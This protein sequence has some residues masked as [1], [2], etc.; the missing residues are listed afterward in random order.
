MHP[1]D[2]PKVMQAIEEHFTQQTNLY[3]TEHRVL[4]KDG[5]YKWILDRGHAIW[6]AEGNAIRI[7]G[8]HTDIS[9]QKQAQEELKES[10]QRLELALEASGDGWW[11]LDIVKNSGYLSPRWWQML[12]Y[13]GDE[14]PHTFATW[15]SLIHPDDFPW[16][17]QI[18]MDYLADYH[19][20][21]YQFDYRLRTRSGE[22]KW[23]TSYGKVVEW[24]ADGKPL[25]M[26]GTHK[27]ISERKP[28]EEILKEREPFL[29]GIGDNFPNGFLYQIV[30]ET[31]GRDRFYY[32]SAGVERLTGLKPKEVLED[33]SLLHHLI[34][35][36]DCAWMKE[37][38]QESLENLSIFDVQ[39]R[40]RTIWDDQYRWV[41]LCSTPRRLNDGRIVWD[42]IHLDITN[43][44]N[45]EETL[46]QNQARLAESQRIAH[47]GN[48]E[49]DLNNGQITWSE[50]LFSILGRDRSL[51]EPNYEENLQL[52]DL[53][54][55]QKLHEAIE[56]AIHTGE[57]YRLTL[58]LA[59][60]SD[61]GIHYIEL[62]GRVELNATG[63]LTRLYGTG[64][65]ITERVQTEQALQAAKDAA[66]TANRAKSE[67]LANMSHEIRTPMNAILGFAD[68]LSSMIVEPQAKAYLD[69][70]SSS[71]KTLLTLIND[72]LD[73]SKIE[74]GK[75]EFYQDP[76]NLRSLIQDMQNI[77][78]QKATEK[79]LNLY[80]KIDEK[81]PAAV[82]TDEVRLRQ[83]L[84][85][86][87]GNAL[88]FTERGSVTLS[89]RAQVYLTEAGERVWLELMVEDTGIGI[90]KNQQKRIFE[91]FVQSD[92]QS[93]RK[94]GG[95]GLGLTI[96]RRLTHKMGG[97]YFCEVR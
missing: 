79:N 88:K 54:S 94:Y 61:G 3:Q 17:M 26:T 8:S 27:D 81:V 59:Q 22:W 16:V 48:W 65:D 41:R 7:V 35:P 82:Y 84:F 25:R 23:I 18:V 58:K 67:F 62:I 47:I 85:N 46:R 5:S 83:I 86:L 19:H 24:N 13:E 50:E 70:I 38:V 56:Q 78:A 2:L 34:L 42:G 1:D 77:F 57:S 28:M 73:L 72:I 95:T 44:K 51:G 96:T 45:T 74:A 40:Q 68:L 89:C 53:P 21:T 66:D 97:C 32:L 20:Q 6:D 30:R 15:Q 12:G 63:Q 60:H 4:C 52:Y 55:Q 80:L 93:T 31:D 87:I 64:Q 91:A 43:L 76:M 14:F 37:K 11:D 75:L 9:Q 10:Q 90:A 39:V 71:G 33:A 29:R 36:E 69:V 49:Y 92:G